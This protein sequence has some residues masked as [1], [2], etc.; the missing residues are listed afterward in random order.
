MG[1]IRIQ[2]ELIGAAAG[3]GTVY[4]WSRLN[5]GAVDSAA[6]DVRDA[7]ETIEYF[8]KPLSGHPAN[9]REL[10][11][12]YAVHEDARERLEKNE[13]HVVYGFVALAGI[14]LAG[15]AVGA[16]MNKRGLANASFAGF[17]GALGVGMFEGASMPNSG[18][19]TP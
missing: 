14:A 19:W 4:A 7:S 6:D 10:D 2:G 17:M 1:M 5:M 16:A 3:A 13:S 12:L 11:E 15:V 8:D 18:E 9:V